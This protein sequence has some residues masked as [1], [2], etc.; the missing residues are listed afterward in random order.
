V[1]D[2]T[3]TYLIFP[4]SADEKK[5]PPNLEAWHQKC[6]ALLADIGGLGEGYSL[7]RWD[8]FIAKKKAEQEAA[9]AAAAGNT[10]APTT[11]ATTTPA[12][13]VTRDP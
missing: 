13:P 10:P 7:H 12:V 9:K 1:S 2:L 11:P 4:G 3:I 8:D 6:S 5:G